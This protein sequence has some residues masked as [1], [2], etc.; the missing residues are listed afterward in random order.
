MIQ[1]PSIVK[2]GIS[3]GEFAT[4]IMGIDH[5]MG[6]KKSVPELPVLPGWS[7]HITS[8]ELLGIPPGPTRSMD[9]VIQNSY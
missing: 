9:W 3:D 7:F 5:H 8:L 6:L 2:K 4:D 1:S